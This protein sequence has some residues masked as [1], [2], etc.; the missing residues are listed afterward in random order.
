VRKKKLDT[1]RTGPQNAKLSTSK[2]ITG[3]TDGM[4][5]GS[6][7]REAIKQFKHQKTSKITYHFHIRIF[8]KIVSWDLPTAIACAFSIPIPAN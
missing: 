2:H 4:G 6:A 3:P 1:S 5:S 7:P 8:L